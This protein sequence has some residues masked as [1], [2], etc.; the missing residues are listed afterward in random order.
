[1]R[2]YTVNLI[3][4]LCVKLKP[5]TRIFKIIGETRFTLYHILADYELLLIV[6]LN[7]YMYMW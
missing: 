7:V 6:I 1:M 3:E 2:D 4:V 5:L